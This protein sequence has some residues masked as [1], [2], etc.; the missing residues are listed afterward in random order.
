MSLN[1]TPSA[2]RLHIGIF[3][4]TNS[5][6]SS[7]INALTNQQVSIV[8][9]I[10]GTTTDPVYKAMEI[11]P[12]GACVIID[13]AGFG[14]DSALGAAR[15]D[16]TLQA[17]DKT[18]I[19]VLIFSD[20]RELEENNFNNTKEVNISDN[21]IIN[22]LE[23]YYHFKSKNTPVLCLINKIEK[24]DNSALYGEF[25][26]KIKQKTGQDPLLINP[27]SGEGMEQIKETLV[28][29][30]PEDFGS[31]FITS[32]LVKEDDMVLLV[33]P[34]DIQAPKGRLILPQVQTIRELLDKKCVVI[35][36]TADKMKNAIEA[37]KNPPKL[38]ITDSQVFGYV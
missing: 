10:S 20:I 28:R 27:L 36:T 24:T 5:G 32:D 15:M 34:Q 16:K 37:L 35:S 6:K 19:A 18:D 22:T 29:L 25:K 7:F 31:Q 12:L 17:A 14:D 1:Q 13:T 9:E 30:I 38:I 3:G 21:K 26:N 2:N 4:Q 11:K 8:S 23:L 33:M